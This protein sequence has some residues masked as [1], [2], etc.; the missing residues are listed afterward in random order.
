MNITKWWKYSGILLIITAILHTL[1][2]LAM[3]WENG[4]F[5][6]IIHNGVFNSI[7]ADFK[8]GM[9]FWFFVCGI[10][11]WIFGQILHYYIKSEQHPAPKF[12]GWSLLIFS[13][14]GVCLAPISG[15]WLF[16]PQGVIILIGK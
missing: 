11:L 2:A 14:F 4:V 8:L 16:I 12:L 10:V 6:D 5:A 9:A 1:V 15:F 7:G 13:I 3:M